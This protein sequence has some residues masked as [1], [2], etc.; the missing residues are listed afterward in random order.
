[1]PIAE[2]ITFERQ[3]V[4]IV[5]DMIENI[6]IL[7]AILHDEYRVRVATSGSQALGMAQREPLPDL[8]LL[9]VVM[10][11]MDGF[12]V[13]KELKQNLKTRPIPIIFI[14]SLG[15]VQDE[16]KGLEIG[17]VDYITKP[18]N[19]AI[20]RARVRT[21]LALYDQNR[22]LELKVQERTRELELSKEELVLSLQKLDFSQREILERLAQAAEL[23]DE[24]TGKHNY[25][26]G[27]ISSMLAAELALP[28]EMVDVIRQAAPLHD[29]G[30][31][32]I[33][34]EVLLKPGRLTPEE[35]AIMQTHTTIGA[36]ILSNG[37]SL[38]VQT[39]ETIALSHH[40][41]WNGNGYPF[42]LAHNQIP[43]EG[44]IVGIADVF[45]ALTHE[46]PYKPAWTI[47]ATLEELS[48]LRG[49]D[50]SPDLVDAFLRLDHQQ[51]I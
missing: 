4:L 21:H 40:E 51:L 48:R 45:D 18:V 37:Q 24:T 13:C 30:K 2:S 26:V 49:K 33:A 28:P 27:L 15:E 25:R 17:A 44:Q 9:D 46:R 20:V 42:G 8:I 1:M 41:R 19:P 10:P 39:A 50:F 14:T 36:N 22:I 47:E 35:F 3:T 34:D 29:V 23:H 11:D 38:L 12:E 7:D 5:D 16:A 6:M 32:G 31:I 43:I